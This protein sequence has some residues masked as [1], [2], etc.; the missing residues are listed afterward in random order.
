M[1]NAPNNTAPLKLRANMVIDILRCLDNISPRL[2]S[3][4]SGPPSMS[5][6]LPFSMWICISRVLVLFSGPG[7]WFSDL[8][9]RGR[10]WV[11]LNAN[12][13]LTIGFSE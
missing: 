12:Y 9:F 5:I 2:N 8:R 4:R 1:N 13:F 7:F 10:S 6:P 3:A 11:V